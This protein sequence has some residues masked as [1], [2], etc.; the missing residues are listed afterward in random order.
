MAHKAKCLT[1]VYVFICGDMFA[2]TRLYLITRLTL[3]APRHV[4]STAGQGVP[5]RLHQAERCDLSTNMRQTCCAV[6]LALG[7][8]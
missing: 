1:F 7:D 5:L 3:K 6:S 8:F 4:V 2:R